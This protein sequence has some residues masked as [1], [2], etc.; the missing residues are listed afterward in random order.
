MRNM[1]HV[2]KIQNILKL[3]YLYCTTFYVLLGT[4]CSILMP[5]KYNRLI[6]YPSLFK[7]QFPTCFDHQ[8][9]FRETQIW[10][11]QAVVT[12]QNY[13]SH[14]MYSLKQ[15]KK[16]NSCHSMHAQYMLPAAYYINLQQCLVMTKP[17][18]KTNQNKFSYKVFTTHFM[19]I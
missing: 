13:K 12:L 6:I 7:S 14:S 5:V 11:L 10:N 15:H 8:I 18:Q 2:C 3:Q 1:F 16:W 17:Q 4:A 9:I 19:M